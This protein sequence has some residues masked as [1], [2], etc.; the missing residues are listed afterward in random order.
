MTAPGC[1]GLLELELANDHRGRTRLVRRVQRFPLRLTVP[2]YLDTDDLGM[3]F[4]YVQNPTGGVFAD[5]RLEVSVEVGPEA[6]GHLT[7]ASATKVYRM[8]KGW[9]ESRL[10]LHLAQGSYLELVP[11]PLIPQA[12]SRL[13][14]ELSATLAAGACLVATE[15]VSPGRLA[16]GE[17][18]AY[19]GLTLRTT[20]AEPEGRELCTDLILLEPARRSPAGRGLLGHRPY[21]ASILVGAPGRDAEAL[22]GALDDAVRDIPGTL[23]GAGA[24]PN[25]AGALARVLAATGGSA[26]AALDAAWGAARGLLLGRSLPPR[27]K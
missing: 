12:G 24:L 22:A 17:A 21:L 2:L 26:R 10:D 11:E 16:R 6:R 23:S 4:L 5:D 9:A 8:E 20:L 13:T 25:G 15:I 18:F 7:T 1:H 19:E 27:R 14:Q 3:A